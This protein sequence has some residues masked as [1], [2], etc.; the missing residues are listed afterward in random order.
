MPFEPTAP[1]CHCPPEQALFFRR[2]T[3]ED[4]EFYIEGVREMFAQNEE[5]F[6]TEAIDRVFFRRNCARGGFLVAGSG[7]RGFVLFEAGHVT[8]FM[9]RGPEWWNRF[10]FISDVYVAPRERGKRL[11]GKMIDCAI[12]MFDRRE[13]PEIFAAVY[14]G[15]ESSLALFRN[16]KFELFY[17][18]GEKQIG[19]KEEDRVEK[20]PELISRAFCEKSDKQLIV[21]GLVA[22]SDRH[23]PD[24]EDEFRIFCQR[25]AEQTSVYVVNGEAVGWATFEVT[26]TTP[27]GV[28]YG[29]YFCEFGFLHYIYILPT[30]G[31][32]GLGG[33]VV[34]GLEQTC[35]ARGVVLFKSCYGSAA[36]AAFHRKLGFTDCIFLLR[37]DNAGQDERVV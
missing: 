28:D 12:G 14:A 37:R 36:S 2:G 13:F 27:Y 16:L 26:R 24:V 5:P 8:P 15:N 1:P 33:R 20:T 19:D 18:I 7:Q 22:T 31:G 23:V 3:P 10:I 4:E 30:F 6:S 9:P 17:T 21:A 29:D 35:R 25:F 32:K 34:H 11:A